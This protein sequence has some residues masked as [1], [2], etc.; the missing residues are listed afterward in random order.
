MLTDAAEI[1]IPAV[2]SVYYPVLTF[3]GTPLIRRMSL[4]TLIIFGEGI[5][6]A[7]NAITRVVQADGH[8]TWSEYNP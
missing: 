2:A 4:L 8:D 6:V 3:Q 7:C 1:L 5:T